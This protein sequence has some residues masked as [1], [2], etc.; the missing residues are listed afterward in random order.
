MHSHQPIKTVLATTLALSAITAPTALANGTVVGPNPDEQTAI[1]SAA[2]S[3]PTQAA[4]V[5]QPNPDTR[6]VD[7]VPPILPAPSVSQRAAILR[8]QA[9][10]RQRLA[11]TAPQSARYSNADTNAYA[12]GTPASIPNAVVRVVSHDGGFDWGDAGIGA[13]GGLALSLVAFGGA[14]TVGRHRERQ[15][16]SATRAAG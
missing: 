5:V 16:R 13:A 8:A 3:S 7:G 10:E 12:S 11:Y 9:Q 6:T 15:L 14:L 4:P 2:T 1:I